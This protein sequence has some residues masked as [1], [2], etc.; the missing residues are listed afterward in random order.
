MKQGRKTERKKKI[1]GEKDKTKESKEEGRENK[2]GM[3]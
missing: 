3:K 2:R 1:K